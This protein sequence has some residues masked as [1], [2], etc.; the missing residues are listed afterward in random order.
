MQRY[1]AKIMGNP[2]M[3]KLPRVD[4][5]HGR[6]DFVLEQ[7]KG[8]KILHLGCVDEGLTEER[9]KAGNLMHIRLLEIAKEVWGIDLSEEGLQFLRERGI[10]NLIY[11]DIEHLDEIEEIRNQEFD[12]IVASEVIEH[13]NNPGLFL[14][15]VKKLFSENTIMIL[16]TP[17]AFRLTELGYLLKGVEFVHPDHNYW[18]SYHTLRSLLRKN[19][20]EVL[21]VCTYSFVNHRL[22]LI[23]SLW[24]KAR[25]LSQRIALPRSKQ[26]L[27]HNAKE[28]AQFGVAKMLKY[29]LQVLIRRLLYNRTPFFADGLIFIVRPARG[30]HGNKN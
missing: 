23:Y 6:T 21:A 3:L 4:I 28:S 18:F 8:K 19:G 26:K 30:L 11:G 5:V 17:N 20:Y 7:C 1:N 29:A 10:S 24:R 22:P 15:S 16:T 13:L 14:Q 9:F 25:G 2:H 27:K 12:I